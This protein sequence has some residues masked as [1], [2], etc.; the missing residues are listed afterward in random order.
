MK[1]VPS[2]RRGVG[3]VSAAALNQTMQVG[4]FYADRSNALSELGDRY[5][6]NSRAYSYLM[7]KITGNTVLST[8]RW[9]YDWEMVGLTTNGVQT[10]TNGYNSTDFGKAVNLC[11][12]VNDGAAIEGPGWNLATAPN[13]FTI[14]PI[15]QA[16]VMLWP[17]SDSVSE[18]RW[19]FQLANVLD[20]ECPEP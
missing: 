20:G 15:D 2:L 5:I 12:M 13:G 17:T 16:V 11:E 9:Q 14:K 3:R 18:F 7:V 4:R 6:D 10:V 1:P 19:F 8:N